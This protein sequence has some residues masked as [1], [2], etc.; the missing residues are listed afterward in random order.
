METGVA[1]AIACIPAGAPRHNDPRSCITR[2]HPARPSVPWGLR[3]RAERLGMLSTA[4]PS[5]SLQRL[6]FPASSGLGFNYLNCNATGEREAGNPPGKHPHP[7]PSPGGWEVPGLRG[8]VGPLTQRRTLVRLGGCA[9]I[10]ASFPRPR[11]AQPE[12]AELKLHPQ[13]G[14]NTLRSGGRAGGL[15]RPSGELGTRAEG[16]SGLR[17]L[18]DAGDPR[19]VPG[20]PLAAPAAAGTVP[21]CRWGH[22]PHPQ[23]PASA[24]SDPFL[25][26]PLI[27][28]LILTPAP[29]IASARAEPGRAGPC[30]E[31]PRA[32][33]PAWR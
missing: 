7:A 16:C 9:P 23:S 30:R 2:V 15:Q 33:P 11:G 20:A 22:A 4:S 17:V 18:E 10:R 32:A 19:V 29:S 14:D 21:G 6:R 31:C 25:I 27:S 8:K 12:S 26:T 28:I 3:S 5:A 13:G 1:G 24:E